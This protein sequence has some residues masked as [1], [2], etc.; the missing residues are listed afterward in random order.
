ML[1]TAPRLELRKGPFVVKLAVTG[2]ERED[3]FRL[4]FDVF[5]IEQ[6]KGLPASYLTSMDRDDHDDH[7]DHLVVT[8]EEQ[9]GR[10]VGTYRLMLGST[11]DS[12]SGYYSEGEFDIAAIRGL[13]GEKLELGRSCVHQDY[14]NANI[15]SL[16]WT[17][18]ARYIE[19]HDVRYV[20]GCASLNTADLTEINEVYSYLRTFHRADPLF[21]VCPFQRVN[22]IEPHSIVDRT[23]AFRKL[24]PLVKG[25]LRAGALICG[26]PAFD[27]EFGTTDLFL[28][29]Q[30]DRL[31]NRYRGRFFS[32]LV[33]PQCSLC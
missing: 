3:A 7:C 12:G 25:Y 5:N 29:L 18:I 6:G 23:A 16:L 27:P 17:G 13:P 4:R 2:E 24:P 8:D 9:H 26:E 14:R 20:F 11:A 22:G 19:M 21:I 10:V 15:I 32:D 30:T 1:K 31:I 28:M 33:E